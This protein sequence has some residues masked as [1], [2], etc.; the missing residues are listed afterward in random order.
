MEPA[1]ISIRNKDTG[2]ISML[3]Q[4]MRF[5]DEVLS[6]CHDGD[7]I[8]DGSVQISIFSYLL[9]KKEINYDAARRDLLAR[10]PNGDGP[11]VVN[12]WK[13]PM[14]DAFDKVWKYVAKVS[15]ADIPAAENIFKK[16]IQIQE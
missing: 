8:V 14:M 10:L 9:Y 16:G 12:Y 15:Q 6:E 11:G 13:K 2:Y 1:T 5:I 7:G 3:E 4:R